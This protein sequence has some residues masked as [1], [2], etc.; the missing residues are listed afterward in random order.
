[1]REAADLAV[2]ARGLLEIEIGKGMRFEGARCDLEMFEQRFA[3]QMRRFSA[4]R[5]YAD[6]DVGFTEVGR[7]QLRVT[8][9]HMQQADI[10]EGRY[11]IEGV[12]L[13]IIGGGFTAENA[14]IQNEAGGGPHGEH[15]QE[16]TSGKAHG[17]FCLKECK[18]GKILMDN[19]GS[20]YRLCI[21]R[22]E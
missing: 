18:P 5:A 14:V 20:C 10:A 17:Q 8:V 22:A 21:R 6:I 7:N 12:R 1:M 11:I 16:F 19:P 9:G 2:A 15:L 13:F 4:R 3:D